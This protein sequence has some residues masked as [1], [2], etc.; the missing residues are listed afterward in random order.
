MDR[1]VQATVESSRTGEHGDGLIFVTSVEHSI[2]IATLDKGD[3]SF[4]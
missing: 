4:T 1:V 3:T 2:N